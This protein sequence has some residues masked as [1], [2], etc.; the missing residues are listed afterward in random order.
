MPSRPVNYADLFRL[1]NHVGLDPA[2]GLLWQF[3]PSRTRDSVDVYVLRDAF[4]HRFCV[5]DWW[6]EFDRAGLTKPALSE[7]RVAVPYLS[8]DPRDALQQTLDALG[9]RG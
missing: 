5:T 1:A 3:E 9:L 8:A 7:G 6:P 2:Q 4:G